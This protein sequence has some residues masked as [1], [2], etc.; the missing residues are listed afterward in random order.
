[1]RAPLHTFKRTR[2]RV[3]TNYPSSISYN[4]VTNGTSK[5]LAKVL[6]TD[7]LNMKR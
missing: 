4:V 3:E 1:L 2:L 6:F 7:A 5:E